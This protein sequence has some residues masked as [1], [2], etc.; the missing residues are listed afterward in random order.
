VKDII[1]DLALA[2]NGATAISDSEY[3]KEPGCTAKVIDG[4]IATP[5]DFSNRWHSSLDQ[6]HPHWVEV[7]LPRPSKISVVVIHF[8][9]P[10]GY[11]VSF[12]GAVRVNG[13]EQQVI[14]VTG[15]HESQVYRAKIGPV[16]TDAFRLTVRASANSAFPNAAQISEIELYP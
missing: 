4:V 1:P 9:D 3:A 5:A 11:P 16:T 10:D 7:H 8:A 15:N 12:E 14:N 6:P 2:V 13:Q